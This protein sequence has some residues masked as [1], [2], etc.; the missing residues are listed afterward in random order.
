MNRR[1]FLAAGA[2]LTA[3][4]IVAAS[5]GTA[6]REPARSASDP[7]ITP[8]IAD[9][10]AATV[11]SCRRLDDTEGG[12]RAALWHMQQ[13]VTEVAGHIRTSRFSDSATRRRTINLWAQLAQTAGWTA[14]DAGLHTRA[15]H[16]YA[17]GLKAAHETADQ[18]LTSH[19]LG[20]LTF[21]A[22]ARG[23][24]HDALTLA[25]AGITA[26][27]SAAPAVRAMAAARKA[28]AHAALGDLTAL[29]RTTDMGL[30]FL[31]H[32]DARDTRPPWLYW[33][34]GLRVVTGQSYITGAFAAGAPGTREAGALLAEA[35]P[36]ITGWLGRH[37][38]HTADRDGL[39]HGAWL[40]RSY[41][42]RDELEH[43][44]ATAGSLL[45][46]AS[47]VPSAH[48]RSTL[49]DLDTDLAARREL[50]SHRPVQRLRADLHELTAS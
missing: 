15:H 17:T 5:P 28:H 23:R 48:V 20:C 26:A 7:V 44:V 45:Q 39:L 40:A 19:I 25:D 22:I 8:G 43:T 12:S 32:P 29:R 41:L 33:L 27:R 11:E 2:A 42:A 18:A 38:E 10:I 47:T 13:Q 50:R 21:Q 49:A 31:A 4:A 14:M 16:Y 46:Y 35:D 30:A 36:L 1:T 9:D 3:P 24:H 37:A 6:S 34:S